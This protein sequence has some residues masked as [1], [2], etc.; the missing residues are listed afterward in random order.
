MTDARILELVD[1]FQDLKPKQLEMVYNI[2]KERIYSQG[3][4]IVEENT[5]SKEMYVILEGDVEVIVDPNKFERGK[6]GRD[7]QRIAL[8]QKG[9]SFGEV[10]LVD[11]GLRSASV[12]CNS[13]TCRVFVIDRKDFMA[14]IKKDVE[15]GFIVMSN[16]AADLCLKIRQTSFFVREKLLYSPS[17]DV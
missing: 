15:L 7:F 8:L 17:K 5:P 16:L 3:T 9:Q 10:A 12:R 1:I 2:C 13:D 14:I 6:E 4:F 11:Q